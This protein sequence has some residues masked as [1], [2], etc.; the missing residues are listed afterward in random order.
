[1]KF[2]RISLESIYTGQY[3]DACPTNSLS[4]QPARPLSDWLTFKSQISSTHSGPS[5]QILL[6]R[7]YTF[8]P[9]NLFAYISTLLCLQTPNYNNQLRHFELSHFPAF[10]K[11]EK[12]FL[13]QRRRTGGTGR[14][15]SGL[16]GARNRRLPVASGEVNWGCVPFGVTCRRV[17]RVALARQAASQQLGARRTRCSVSETATTVTGAQIVRSTEKTR[18]VA[19]APCSKFARPKKSL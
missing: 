7:L 4:C 15:V 13:V 11:R 17:S 8:I 19:C 6:P 2:N 10:F 14:V 12:L 9:P 16:I 18:W 5:Q 3:G 1:M